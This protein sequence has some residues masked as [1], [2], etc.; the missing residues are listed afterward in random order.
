M[1]DKMK[2]YP[3]AVVG[4]LVLL[5]CVGGIYLRFDL[6]DQLSARES[7]LIKR[8]QTI[9]QNIKNSK[10][11]GTE[12]EVLSDQIITINERLFRR[13]A[14]SMNTNFFY[15]FEDRLDIYISDVKQLAVESPALMKGGA[16]ELT[17]YSGIMYDV[18]L[19]GTF[20]EILRFIYEVQKVD[21]LMRVADF[22]V[23]S[24][25]SPG[26]VPGALRG[27]LRIAVL[28]EK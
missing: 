28:A 8:M 13:S 24:A 2:Q 22:E 9:N 26:A 17:L 16:K 23:T 14:R 3:A 20:Q 27:Q 12:V 15:S 10:N 4:A 1:V 5:L 6:V 21:S 7:Q 18:T 25:T 19:I 11:L